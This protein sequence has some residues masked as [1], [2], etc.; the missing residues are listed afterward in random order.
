MNKTFFEKM[1][2]ERGKQMHKKQFNQK[3]LAM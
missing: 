3:L 2:E 1:N